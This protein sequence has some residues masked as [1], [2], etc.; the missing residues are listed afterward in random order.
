MTLFAIIALALAMA[1]DAFAVSVSH[2]ARMKQMQWGLAFRIAIVF[3]VFQGLMPLIGWFVGR[4]AADFANQYGKWIAFAMLAGIAVKMLWETRGNNDDEDMLG[5]DDGIV[6]NS[7]LLV[8]GVATSIDALAAGVGLAFVNVSIYFAAT[9]IAIF[10][11]VLSAF[12]VWIGRQIG[13]LVGKWAEII[14][15]LILLALAVSFLM[16]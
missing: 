15:A 10:T 14:G 13:A 12:G 3:G 6:S 4:A 7:E 5:G 8:A 11:F 2:G 9:V 1:A 16:R